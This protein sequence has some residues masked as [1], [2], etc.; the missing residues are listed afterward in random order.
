[1]LLFEKYLID[2]MG[3]GKNVIKKGTLRG[4]LGCSR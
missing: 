1:M 3:L 4:C 2:K